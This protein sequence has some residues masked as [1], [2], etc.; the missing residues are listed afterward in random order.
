MHSILNLNISEDVTSK[1]TDICNEQEIVH[2]H[3]KDKMEALEV[4][5]DIE[6]K[7][8]WKLLNKKKSQ[9]VGFQISFS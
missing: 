6:V 9:I 4:L 5:M 1:I 2:T 8:K 3:T 7:K